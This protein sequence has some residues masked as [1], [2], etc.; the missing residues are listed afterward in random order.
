MPKA[1]A[2]RL[3]TPLASRRARRIS[4]VSSRFTFSVRGI[5][6]T[7]ISSSFFLEENRQVGQAEDASF[8]ED[9]CSLDRIFELADV[10]GKGVP[11]ERRHG[12]P[13][14]PFNFFPF[15]GCILLNEEIDKR[16][17]VLLPRPKRWNV[18]ADDVQPLV[19][20]GPE[21]FFLHPFLQVSVG[22]SDN[23]DIGAKWPG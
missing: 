1:R 14:D 16:R 6:S 20:V 4:L 15:P 21:F 11:H 2:A 8:A 5:S 12:F 7:A 23:P 19:K 3:L 18:D 22:G 10:S 9:D 17:N 13:G